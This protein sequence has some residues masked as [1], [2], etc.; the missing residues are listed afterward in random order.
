VKNIIK[1]TLEEVNNW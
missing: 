1:Q